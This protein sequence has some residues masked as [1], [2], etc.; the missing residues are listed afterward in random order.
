MSMGGVFASILW[1]N[2]NIKIDK[3]IMESFPLLGLEN[4][5]IKILPKQLGGGGGGGG[6][7]I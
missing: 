6:G 4:F 5:M 3:L 7:G 2:G 1:Q